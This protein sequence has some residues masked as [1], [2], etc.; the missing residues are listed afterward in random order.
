MHALQLT[1]MTI[2]TA[3]SASSFMT[4]H[5]NDRQWEL[6]DELQALSADH[7]DDNSDI[8]FTAKHY[9]QQVIAAFDNT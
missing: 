1:L 8:G 6:I 5:H 2:G 4:Q 9:I 7:S 3:F